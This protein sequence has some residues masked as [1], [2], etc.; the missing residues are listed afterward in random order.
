ML[1]NLR[2]EMI[3]R[4][5]SNLDIQTVLSC[6]SKTVT[7]KLSAETDF[8]FPEALSV[9]DALFPGLPLEYLFAKSEA[10]DSA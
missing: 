5:I 3:R 2:V 9:R 8:S 10:R 6:S 1:E 4:G 7:N